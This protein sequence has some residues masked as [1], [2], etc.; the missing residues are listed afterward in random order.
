MLRAY[1]SDPG[2]KKV[3]IKTAGRSRRGKK[4]SSSERPPAHLPAQEHSSE[5]VAAP[6]AAAR[7]AKFAER[8]HD[9][10]RI[11]DLFEVSYKTALHVV[12]WHEMALHDKVLTG[13]CPILSHTQSQCKA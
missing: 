11:E 12:T 6:V 13:I 8:L 10:Q 1:V 5:P 9:A 2:T 7:R 4:Q 3:V